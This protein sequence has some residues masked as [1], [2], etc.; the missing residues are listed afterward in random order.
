M[1]VTP[2]RFRALLEAHQAAGKDPVKLGKAYGGLPDDKKEEFVTQ[3][4]G[5]LGIEQ[6]PSFADKALGA[7]KEYVGK[8]LAETIRGAGRGLAE[9]GYMMNPLNWP[10][11]M[12]PSGQVPESALRPEEQ[13][14]YPREKTVRYPV[15]TAP[16]MRMGRFAYE[17]G[18]KEDV[19]MVNPLRETL[20]EKAEPIVAAAPR[21]IPIIGPKAQEEFVDAIRKGGYELKQGGLP[22]LVADLA[23]FGIEVKLGTK[24][25]NKL[26]PSLGKV[27]AGGIPESM[28]SS[29]AMQQGLARVFE[30]GIPFALSAWKDAL[31]MGGSTEDQAAAMIEAFMMS[32]PFAG[33]KAR[34][35]RK[36]G[37][38]PTEE[39]SALKEGI[40]RAPQEA[41]AENVVN[42]L[43]RPSETKL[44]GPATE[45][46]LAETTQRL[47]RAGRL[48]VPEVP[49]VGARKTV[50]G[51]G[52]YEPVRFAGESEELAKMR[53]MSELETGSY[54]GGTP[55]A[56]GENAPIEFAGEPEE[57]ALQRERARLGLTETE[58]SPVV[59]KGES[60]PIEFAG[61]PGDVAALR[62]QG[63]LGTSSYE[64]K[65]PRS[66]GEAT[67]IEFAGEPEGVAAL[68]EKGNLGLS[69]YEG[70][71]PKAKG[72]AGK[73]EFAGEPESIAEMKKAGGLHLSEEGKAPKI[74]AEGEGVRF[75]SEPGDITKLKKASNL[76][77]AII[78]APVAGLSDEDTRKPSIAVA[79]GLVA[80]AAVKTPFG[81]SLAKRLLRNVPKVGRYL[82]GDAIAELPTRGWKGKPPEGARLKARQRLGYRESTYPREFAVR[83]KD[84]Y[85]TVQGAKSLAN[86]LLKIGD[87][88][89]KEQGEFLRKISHGE[90]SGMEPEQLAEAKA[91]KIPK[92]WV[93]QTVAFRHQQNIL[94]EEAVTYGHMS[95]ETWLKEAGKHVKSVYA[96]SNPLN[97]SSKTG[98]VKKLFRRSASEEWR[99]ANEIKD[100]G[101]PEYTT[102]VEDSTRNGMSKWIDDMKRDPFLVPDIPAGEA[103]RVNINGQWYRKLEGKPPEAFNQGTAERWIAETFGL[104]GLQGKYVWEPLAEELEGM[105]IGA[106]EVGGMMEG[107][108]RGMGVWK[109]F[110]AAV[111]VANSVGNVIWNVVA[112]DVHMPT[113]SLWSPYGAKLFKR[114]YVAIRDHTKEYTELQLHNTFGQHISREA[115]DKVMSKMFS[116]EPPEGMKAFYDRVQGVTDKMAA[117]YDLSE[118]LSKMML[119]IYAQE[120]LGMSVKEASQY[121]R[122]AIF[123]YTDVP[124]VLRV[125]R[126]VPFAG[127]PFITFAYK[128]SNRLPS[129]MMNL[130]NP[131]KFWKYPAMT[132]AAGYGMKKAFNYTDEEIEEAAKELPEWAPKYLIPG[133]PVIDENG[134]RRITF[135]SPKYLLPM[136]EL[137]ESRPGEFPLRNLFRGGPEVGIKETIDNYSQYFEG[138]IT[139]KYETRAIDKAKTLGGHLIET[140]GPEAIRQGRRVYQAATGVKN[141]S[142]DRKYYLLPE[143]AGLIGLKSYVGRPGM[144]EYKRRSEQKKL[145]E[146]IRSIRRNTKDPKVSKAREDAAWEQFEQKVG[147]IKRVI[148]GAGR[149][150]KVV[151]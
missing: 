65:T 120:E 58:R 29:T 72:E 115:L 149:G 14:R 97:I 12:Y 66:T 48:G 110:K 35:G 125:V 70:K 7:A 25:L 64:G 67:P 99:E 51:K 68:K 119:G 21:A 81:E 82:S 83:T 96:K 55:R 103:R 80:L 17:P 28:L 133:F 54:E 148:G 98:R 62:E 74:K 104:R 123:D 101:Y 92:K 78:A 60:A 89:S 37:V 31:L 91:L 33:L 49:E 26:V 36:P 57:L 2:E 13:S 85:D 147:P 41:Y 142:G 61:E 38:K 50:K 30:E 47:R 4:E 121:A 34:F 111:N 73:I 23:R 10:E 76:N 100:F 8:P 20:L 93:N 112:T 69:S 5:V 56:K 151:K 95:K 11:M 117:H 59:G 140:L 42:Q 143:L 84:I 139:K 150:L 43:S 18:Q 105:A 3:L 44:L 109:T 16:E 9:T 24:F 6:G 1:S 90:I 19:A 129:M 124:K 122:K 102:M 87:K 94:G 75:E 77:P 138:P 45:E 27:I 135:M 46:G 39:L 108:I 114:A 132:V 128:L 136:A 145:V 15:T 144:S 146:Q 53:R 116:G 88:A 137:I 86:D 22:N 32:V 106:K 127:S 52:G 113:K 40:E 141:D 126:N 131:M 71:T 63:K 107:W 134:K 130:A 79:A 118:R